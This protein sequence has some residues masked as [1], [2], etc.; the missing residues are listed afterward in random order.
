[1]QLN[2]CGYSHYVT[3]SLK[4]GLVCLL[5]IGFTFIESTYRTYSMILNCALFTSPLSVQAL[6]SSSCLSYTSYIT[7]AD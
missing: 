4:R 2:F 7:T 6:Q 5:W 1:L 3:S